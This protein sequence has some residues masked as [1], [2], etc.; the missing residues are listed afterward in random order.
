MTLADTP[1]TAETLQWTECGSE[2][3]RAEGVG[4]ARI[5]RA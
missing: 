5:H 1:M 4:S 2:S 3:P